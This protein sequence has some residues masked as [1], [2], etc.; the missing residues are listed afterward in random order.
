[1]QDWCV[2]P[3]ESNASSNWG[4]KFDSMFVSFFV[5]TMLGPQHTGPDYQPCEV[6]ILTVKK[7]YLTM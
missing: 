7:K 4:L 6:L 3:N 5:Q 2:F 1:M